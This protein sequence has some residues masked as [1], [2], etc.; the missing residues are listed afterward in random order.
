M[1]KAAISESV[2]QQEAHQTEIDELIK[3]IADLECQ[4]E[5]AACLKDACTEP[6]AKSVQVQREVD[7]NAA[8]EKMQL[9][10][11]I[12]EQEKDL[13]HLKKSLAALSGEPC[14][15]DVPRPQPHTSRVHPQASGS[16]P[17]QDPWQPAHSKQ[18]HPQNHQRLQDLWPDEDALPDGFDAGVQQQRDCSAKRA[19]SGVQLPSAEARKEPQQ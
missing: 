13:E 1:M 16:R 4:A 9:L 18:C 12:S 17:Q 7:A 10:N 19:A 14:S 3:E 11:T 6:P 5:D 8:K 15:S 2:L